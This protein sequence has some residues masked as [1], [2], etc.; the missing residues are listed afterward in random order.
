MLAKIF[1]PTKRYRRFAIR[2]SRNSCAAYAPQSCCNTMLEHH[3][4]QFG[5]GRKPAFCLFGNHES[6]VGELY[7][8][9][10]K[11]INN[12]TV[13]YTIRHVGY[14]SKSRGERHILAHERMID[15]MRPPRHVMLTGRRRI[16]NA[17]TLAALSSS[18]TMGTTRTP[19]VATMRLND[20]ATLERSYRQ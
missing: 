3:I 5:Q 15:R 17:P 13:L 9:G 19:G 10:K 14:M 4:I 11:Y 6:N 2:Q 12:G 1:D 18:S 7:A 16:E 8:G 20:D